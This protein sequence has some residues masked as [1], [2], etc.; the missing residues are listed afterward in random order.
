M[1]FSLFDR[2]SCTMKYLLCEE[3]VMCLS[4]SDFRYILLLVSAPGE[5]CCP[6]SADGVILL[7]EYIMVG[8]GKWLYS[9]QRPVS[10]ALQDRSAQASKWMMKWQHKD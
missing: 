7:K 8:S 9:Q 6:M 2:N 10:S 5:S 1:I 4:T 3:E